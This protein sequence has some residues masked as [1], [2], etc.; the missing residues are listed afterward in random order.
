[1]FLRNPRDHWRF[2]VFTGAAL[3]VY[4]PAFFAAFGFHSD[5][6]LLFHAHDGHRW[7]YQWDI[8][9]QSGRFLGAV[10]AS[11]QTWCVQ[12]IAD[13]TYFRLASFLVLLVLLWQ[14]AR[15]LQ[16]RHGMD[17]FWSSSLAFAVF[18]LPYS[19][20]NVLWCMSFFPGTVT[21]ALAALSYF[22]FEKARGDNA[23]LSA[24]RP[25]VRSVALL[26]LSS[27]FFI[28][29]LF[30]YPPTALIVFAFSFLN[31]VALPGRNGTKAWKV[32]IADFM[33][34]GFCMA[35]Y[36]L[37]NWL[38]VTLPMMRAGKGFLTAQA[39]LYKVSLTDNLVAKGPL[40]WDILT[41]SLAGT[42]HQLLGPWGAVPPAATIL[43]C[44]L[45]LLAKSRPGQISS[46]AL[47]RT[48]LG[49]GLIFLSAN[50][51]TLLAQGC[52]SIVGYRVLFAGSV[53]ALIVQVLL[54]QG[55][56]RALR[57]RG[58]RSGVMRA[59]AVVLLLAWTLTAQRNVVDVVR[60]L[61]RELGIIRAKV[62]TSDFS[63]IEQFNVVMI[64]PDQG[65]TLIGRDLPFE[66][67]YMMTSRDHFQPAL[68][69]FLREIPKP[70]TVEFIF[71]NAMPG[72]IIY[73]DDKSEVIDF[74]EH[75]PGNPSAPYLRERAWVSLPEPLPWKVRL[76]SI[77][78]KRSALFKFAQFTDQGIFGF[79]DITD[80][81]SPSW[82]RVDFLGGPKDV[83][84][85]RVVGYQYYGVP[86]ITLPN[87]RLQGSDDGDFWKELPLAADQ[88]PD[89]EPGARLYYVT[90]VPHFYRKYRVLFEMDGA[91]QGMRVESVQMIF[92]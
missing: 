50:A 47:F 20:V 15:Y 73:F 11:V 25:R 35:V 23:V 53:L 6:S 67:S 55:A 36:F 34:F 13:F 71:V 85:I 68:M 81:K 42:W 77:N 90:G 45:I 83:S 4:A 9:V 63:R 28:T 65:L 51:P 3:L 19:Q 64:P 37:L 33:V 1:M 69:E 92:R 75:R 72:E 21:I 76:V 16:E 38:L 48:V 17:W 49:G 41:L 59:W 10:A 18:L 58:A 22:L 86:M 27:V 29:A 52:F 14:A 8:L 54:L 60:N 56:D 57:Q 30:I 46:G 7:F 74:N 70:L 88:A 79:W 32:L 91:A 40:L 31:F 2:A 5:Y 66:F 26:A 89:A 62:A 84:G 87:G 12:R 82:L 44:A 24:R 61:T 39:C 43:V 78:L 80:K